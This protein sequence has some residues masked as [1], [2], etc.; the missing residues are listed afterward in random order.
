MLDSKPAILRVDTSPRLL[1]VKSE[2][3]VMP[4][5]RGYQ[6]VIQVEDVH[7]GQVYTMF[8]SAVS[9][10]EPLEKIRGKIGRLIGAQIMVSKESADPKS[11]YIVEQVE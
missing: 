10:T 6:P 4:T 2:P 9:L 11:Q 8:V 1:L 3:F 7:S 5:R